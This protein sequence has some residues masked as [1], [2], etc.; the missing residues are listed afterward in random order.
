MTLYQ[1]EFTE[2]QLLA[3]DGITGNPKL[4][5]KIDE[6][7]KARPVTVTLEISSE[8]LDFYLSQIED[9]DQ[10]GD[11]LVHCLAEHKQ[12]IEDVYGAQLP[13]EVADPSDEQVDFGERIRKARIASGLS[14]NEFASM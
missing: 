12:Y 10:I 8:L 1:V 13:F 3:L 6:I 2:E 14:V 4:Q 11:Y 9:E 7:K 5:A